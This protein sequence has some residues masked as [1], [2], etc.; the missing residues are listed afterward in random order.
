MKKVPSDTK[1]LVKDLNA[2][3]K[4]LQSELIEA[5]KLEGKDPF[6]GVKVK[7]N[8]GRAERVKQKDAVDTLVGTSYLEIEITAK[9]GDVFIPISIASGKKVAGFMYQIEGTAEGRIATADVRVRG[10]GVLQVTVGT[11]HYAK[12]PAG[13]TASFE[14]RST[15]RGTFGKTYA[16]VIT[17]IHY[18]LR[19]ADA[20]YEQYLKG[21]H[22][23]T[24]W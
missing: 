3:L 19:L 9:D 21:I 13:K 8:Q 17:R 16:I 11:V 4:V 15:I 6:I 12:I 14:I 20:R 18:K 23:A 1:K 24:I 7:K 2:K 5:N 22:G 10:E